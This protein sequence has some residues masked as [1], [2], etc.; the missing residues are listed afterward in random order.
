MNIIHN[1]I[2]AFVQVLICSCNHI[3]VYTILNTKLKD[4]CNLDTYV[5]SP[6]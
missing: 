5:P 2:Y 3:L 4:F 1:M 6:S